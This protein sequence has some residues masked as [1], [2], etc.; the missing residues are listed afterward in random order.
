MSI[1]YVVG[2]VL[3]VAAFVYLIYAMLRPEK[4]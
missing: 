4:F 1:D 3:S 2:L